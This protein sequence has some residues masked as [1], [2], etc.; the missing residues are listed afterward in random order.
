MAKVNQ[1]VY[2][3]LEYQKQN[4]ITGKCVVNSVYLRDYLLSIGMKADVK[5]VIAGYINEERKEQ[6]LVC[7]MVVETEQGIVDP[8]YEI[9]QHDATYVDKLHNIKGWEHMKT[10]KSEGLS[11]RE[12]ITNFISFIKQADE[13]NTEDLT[14][15][16]SAYDYY[17][18]QHKF[19]SQ[20]L[21]RQV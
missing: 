9:S 11:V 8:S 19:V 7:H 15:S 4:N 5:A 10:C 13:I 17:E 3:M 1:L 20:T 12:V 2:A 14:V 21:T 16:G 6:F 18:A